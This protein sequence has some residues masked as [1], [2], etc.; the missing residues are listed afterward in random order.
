MSCLNNCTARGFC[1]SA[2]C[3]CDSGFALV[4]CSGIVTPGL[5]AAFPAVRWFWFS[6]ATLT[7]AIVTWRLAAIIYAKRDSYGRYGWRIVLDRQVQAL[8]V[9]VAGAISFMVVDIQSSTVTEAMAF[10]SLTLMIFG[11]A[12]ASLAGA[13]AAVSFVP[14]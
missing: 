3:F 4:D 7:L 8:V 13:L 1:S 10:E 14:V 11:T 2:I 12:L 6:L 5:Q 9:E